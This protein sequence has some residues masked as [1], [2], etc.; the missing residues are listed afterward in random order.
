M[1]V[2]KLELDARQV[3]GVLKQV[4]RNIELGCRISKE[5]LEAADSYLREHREERVGWEIER[6]QEPKNLLTPFGQITY[7]RTYYRHKESGEYAHLV[8][9]VAEHGP[10][11]RVD[12][13]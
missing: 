13:P 1:A 11:A 2:K 8:D 10:H 12:A 9:R 6:R 7:R 3:C 5:V 4:P